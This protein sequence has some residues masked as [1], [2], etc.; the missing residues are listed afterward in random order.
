MK[1]FGSY[2]DEAVLK[3]FG[4]TLR[5]SWGDIGKELRQM[6]GFWTSASEM[7]KLDF[8]YLFLELSIFDVFVRE[9]C[10]APR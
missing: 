6:C 9:E 4:E 7:S 3:A 8:A 2:V 5:R 1:V 10:F